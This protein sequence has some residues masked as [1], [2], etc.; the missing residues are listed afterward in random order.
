MNRT[1][2]E[3]QLT[4]IILSDDIDDVATLFVSPNLKARCEELGLP[5]V[6]DE[7]L[8]PGQWAIREPSDIHSD[9]ASG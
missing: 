5:C 9:H 3:L 8:V 6:V 2:C 7:Q 1:E 4:A